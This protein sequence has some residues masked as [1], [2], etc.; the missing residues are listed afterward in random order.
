LFLICA[1]V[2]LPVLSAQGMATGR[3]VRPGVR[4]ETDLK[5]IEVHFEDLA[6]KAGLTTVNVFGD[7]N[8]KRYIVETTGNGVT[9]FDL[10]TTAGW[11]FSS[12]TGRR[13]TIP[14]RGAR[15]STAT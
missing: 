1:A 4:V 13:S 12:P 5:P 10:T 11:I 9:I 3:A 2:W 8:Q 15:F 6:V 14:T 7:P